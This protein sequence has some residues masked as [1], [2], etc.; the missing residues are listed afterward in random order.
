[1]P[2]GKL[3]GM[4]LDELTEL[5][6]AHKSFLE[7]EIQDDEEAVKTWERT[8]QSVQLRIRVNKALLKL[9]K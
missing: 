7:Q 6:N 8:I 1:M 9:V 3:G 5:V 2:D 4:N